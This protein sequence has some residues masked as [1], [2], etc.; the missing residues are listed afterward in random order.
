MRVIP[1]CMYDD[2]DNTVSIEVHRVGPQHQQMWKDRRVVGPLQW[3]EVRLKPVIIL[4]ALF[5]IDHRHNR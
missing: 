3:Q 2:G 4:S 1:W 5:T